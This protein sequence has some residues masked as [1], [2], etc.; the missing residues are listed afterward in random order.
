MCSWPAV[1]NAIIV[2]HPR[3]PPW[4]MSLWPYLPQIGI[5]KCTPT[6]TFDVPTD[7]FYFSEA[8]LYPRITVSTEEVCEA[9]W[10]EPERC[11]A[12]LL[13][14]VGVYLFMKLLTASMLPPI[15]LGLCMLGKS[16]WLR[17]ST[18]VSILKQDEDGVESID[19]VLRL[20]GQTYRLLCLSEKFSAQEVVQC[21]AVMVDLSFG[22]GL[23]H[24]PFSFAGFYYVSVELLTY[25]KAVRD[26]Q[27]KFKDEEEMPR[28]PR[29]MMAFWL[30]V[31]GGFVALH[32]GSTAWTEPSRTTWA[33]TVVP[34]TI[35]WIVCYRFSQRRDAL[36]AQEDVMELVTKAVSGSL[37][38]DTNDSPAGQA[39][40][41]QD[42]PADEQG[43]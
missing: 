14:V 8:K 43:C 42:G 33:I 25:R 21:V 31:M 12:R 3:P 28:L 17:F 18:P 10:T 24:P 5:P 2:R 38:N 1:L 20:R 26:V 23:L 16:D 7:M 19:V 29:A 37:L 4:M 13:E 35:M 9:R 11:T 27:L 22:W 40:I 6:A 41:A 30:Q 36:A 39:Q 34:M 15:F 32:F